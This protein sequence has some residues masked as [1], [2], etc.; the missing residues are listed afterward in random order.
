MCIL[1]IMLEV[2]LILNRLNALSLDMVTIILVIDFGMTKRKRLL[3]VE[4]LYSMKR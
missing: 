3:E 1:V 4:M 2:N